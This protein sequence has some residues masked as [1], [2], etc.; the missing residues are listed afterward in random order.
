ML[1]SKILV[2]LKVMAVINSCWSVASIVGEVRSE[3]MVVV[4]PS[5]H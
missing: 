1:A 2:P 4:M 3:S 5:D